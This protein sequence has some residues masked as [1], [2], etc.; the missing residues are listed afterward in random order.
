MRNIKLTLEYDGTDFCGW[1]VQPQGRTVQGEVELALTNLLQENIRV[2]ASGRTD[3]GVHALR[4]VANFK[5]NSALR[6]DKMKLGVNSNLPFDIRVLSAVEVS[7]TFHARF[8]AVRR[9]YRYRISTV[10]TA[11]DRRYT[12][13][14]RYS[15][16]MEKLRAA[17]TLLIGNHVFAGLSKVNAAE[18]HYRC[19]VESI[20]WTLD[21]HELIFEI[22]ANRFL[23]SMVRIIV[24]T[25]V[26]V[27]RGKFSVERVREILESGD[28][29][30]AGAA[31]PPQGLFL[32]DVQ[33]Q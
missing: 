5:T 2:I 19:Q 27:G 7:P 6:C 8:D 4:Q 32:I 33:Y 22:S 26:E 30:L 15:L 3:A 11:I 21:G 16:D 24:G 28:R 9:S 13:F 23:H 29:T 14:C 10:P 17:S 25:L 20:E 1:Q 18:K 12:W 31:V